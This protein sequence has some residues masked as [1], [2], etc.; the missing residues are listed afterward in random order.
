MNRFKGPSLKASDLR[1]AKI[2][3]T[4]YLDKDILENLR[5]VAEDSGSKYQTV[6]NHILKDYLFGQKKGL[7]ARISK[8][9]KAVSQL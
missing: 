6:L 2:R 3:I 8:L 1:N 5:Q 7:V 9:E 4:T